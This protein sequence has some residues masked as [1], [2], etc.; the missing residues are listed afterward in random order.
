M[1]VFGFCKL[2]NSVYVEKNNCKNEEINVFI[3]LAFI[4]N[5]DS[6]YVFLTKTKKQLNGLAINI[7]LV[8]F[9]FRAIFVN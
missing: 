5:I 6:R 1:L 3:N 8:K 9:Y 2:V 7:F 4:K